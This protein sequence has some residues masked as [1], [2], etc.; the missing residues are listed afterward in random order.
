MMLSQ[1]ADKYEVWYTET[2]NP[3][4]ELKMMTLDASTTIRELSWWLSNIRDQHAPDTK[5]HIIRE[6]F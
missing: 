1:M 4:E 2:D 5:I 6:H 3:N